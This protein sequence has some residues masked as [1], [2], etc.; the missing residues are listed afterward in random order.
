MS[1][2]TAK[3]IVEYAFKDKIDLVGEPYIYHLT[4]VADKLE[5]KNEEIRTVAFLHDLLEDCPEWNKDVL[6]C[7]FYGSVVD[8]VVALTK[9]KG[10]DYKSYISRVHANRYATIVKIADLQDNMNIT[11]LNELTE[12]DVKRLKKYLDAYKFLT[13]N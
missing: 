13:S 5:N 1:L 11:R 10:E 7:F 6:K 2:D 12:K 8:A 9:V 4:R 3:K